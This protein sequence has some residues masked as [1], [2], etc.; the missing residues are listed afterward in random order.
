[1]SVLW[2]GMMNQL[3][4]RFDGNQCILVGALSF[5][6]AAES[7]KLIA[8][9][10]EREESLSVSFAEITHVDSAATAFM[11]ELYRQVSLAGG[12][13]SFVDVPA[14]LLSVLAMTRL[15]TVLPIAT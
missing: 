9:L 14:P 15:D 7:E 12:Q 2:A 1:M 3:E 10:V 8:R 6:S 11:V 5:D 4:C 13:L